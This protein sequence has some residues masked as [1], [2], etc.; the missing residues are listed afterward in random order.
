MSTQTT[1]MAFASIP[2][3]QSQV[4]MMKMKNEDRGAQWV[5]R[6]QSKKTT[7]KTNPEGRDFLSLVS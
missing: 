7:K 3:I 4:L 5:E 1:S 2:W 6:E